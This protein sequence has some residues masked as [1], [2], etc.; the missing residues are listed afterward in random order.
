LQNS[1][2]EDRASGVGGCGKRVVVQAVDRDNPV[3]L[4]LF[5]FHAKPVGVAH[6]VNDGDHRILVH[7]V[8]IE[9][10][11]DDVAIINDPGIVDAKCL[12]A[13]VQGEP[14]GFLVR[15]FV[16]AVFRIS[17]SRMS[18]IARFPP[19]CRHCPVKT[20]NVAKSLT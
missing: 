8:E 10:R 20:F 11:G 5:D 2:P 12:L 13:R 3:S 18:G 6:L 16:A 19:A 4:I 1:P 15:V 17:S 14:P 9:V 7:E